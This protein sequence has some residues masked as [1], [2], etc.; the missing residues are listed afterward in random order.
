MARD[1]RVTKI[2]KGTSKE[3]RPHRRAK[4]ATKVVATSASKTVQN[5]L[6]HNPEVLVVLEIAKRARESQAVEPPREIG[7]TTDVVVLPT[8]SQCPVQ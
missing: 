5:G 3:R 2:K 4:V 1:K 6:K 8:N 7:G